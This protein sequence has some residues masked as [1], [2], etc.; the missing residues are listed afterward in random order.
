[1]DEQRKMKYDYNVVMKLCFRR[2]IESK[3]QI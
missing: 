2:G 1:M 3:F